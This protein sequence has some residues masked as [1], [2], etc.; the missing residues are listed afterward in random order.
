[1]SERA[2]ADS[3]FI[4]YRRRPVYYSPSSRTALAESELKYKDD[5]ESRSVYVGF[6]VQ[7][8]ALREACGGKR[9][10]LLVWTTTPWTLPSNMGVAVH[11][12]MQYVLARKGEDVY[13]VGEGLTDM[14]VIGRINGA[15][16]WIM[17]NVG[18]DLVGVR[19]TH[20]FG[21]GAVIHSRYV[22]SAGTGLV[23]TAPAH[24]H[25]DYEVLP[26]AE[27]KCPVDDDG[28]FTSAAAPELAGKAVLGKGTDAVIEMLQ[29]HGSLFAEERIRH[30]YPYDWK[31]KQPIIIRATPQWFADLSEIKGMANKALDDV[32][33]YPL[34]CECRLAALTSSQ[35]PRGICQWPLRVVHFSATQ[36]GR[37]HTGPFQGWRTGSRHQGH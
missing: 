32:H 5:H 19:Y 28:C 26:V 10:R 37:T 17:A 11:R 18:S 29:Q 16:N 2:G 33:F 35:S 27:L 22:T 20:L 36:L 21:D 23:H 4:S 8:D 9:L 7:D 31:T 30:R 13:V 3:G 6:D 15:S 12:D 25:E 1:M 34:Q 24:G 14:E